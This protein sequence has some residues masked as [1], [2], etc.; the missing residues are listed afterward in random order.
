MTILAIGLGHVSAY[1]DPFT[2]ITTGPIVTDGTGSRSANFV[3]LNNDGYPDILITNGK[4]G[5]ANNLVYLND[6]LGGFTQVNSGDIVSDGKASDGAAVADFNNDGYADVVV[7]NWYNQHNLLYQSTGGTDW[8]LLGAAVPSSNN[9]Y[10]EAASWADYDLDGDLDLF[11]ANSDGDN[12]N[13]L[14]RNDGEAGFVRITDGPVVTD[15][16]LSRCGAWCDYDNDGDPDLYVTNEV[17]NNSFY[18]NLGDGTFTK[19]TDLVIVSDPAASWSASWGDLNNDGNQDLFV[20]NNSA[21]INFLYINNGDKTFSRVESG[22]VVE[23]PT[24]STGSAWVD[25]D[26]DGDLDLFAAS[27]WGASNAHKKRNFLYVNDGAGNLSF[28]PNSVVAV[29]SGWSYGCAF[30]DMDRDGDQDLVVACWQFETENNRLYS[31][32]SG[33]VNNWLA[34]NCIGLQSNNSAIGTKVRALATIDG[35]PRWQYR[36]I[37]SVDG[38]C[39]QS[40]LEVEFG[41]LDATTV[42]SLVI[43][44]PLGLEEVYTDIPVNQFLAAAEGKGLLCDGVDS[45]RDGWPDVVG[46]AP[47]G[48]DN[49][50]ANY[51]PAQEDTNNDGIG[52]ACCCLGTRGNIND[53]PSDATNIADVTYL[54]AYLFGIPPGPAPNCPIEANA[55]GDPAESV[56][57][58]DLTYLVAY[59]FGVPNGPAPPACS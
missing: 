32:D 15:A 8:T 3:D 22:D 31:N 23:W 27:G 40:S 16:F 21:Q 37:M 18:E 26:N 34:I 57:V 9:G 4:F 48:V 10:S 33:Q 54:V 19:I 56:N 30:G 58:S 36:E 46:S 39:S 44:W 28:H 17:G 35:S 55:N 20:A 43:R 45:D 24:Y 41:L 52:D 29:D 13:F 59:L 51:N 6:G 1:G 25:Y 50:A 12:K 11:I 38:Y 14:Y 49:C 7:A 2:K 5:G 53:D 47:C 42:D